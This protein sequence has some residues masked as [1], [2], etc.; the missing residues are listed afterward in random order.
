MQQ[1]REIEYGSMAY[2][3]SL[4][5]RNRVMRIPLGRNL[6]EEDL[7]FERDAV[8][9]GAYEA[10]TLIGTGVMVRKGDVFSLEFLC[11]DTACQRAG[12]GGQLLHWLE[13]YARK[14]Q[15]DKITMHARTSAQGFYE[16]H[17]YCATNEA[18]VHTGAPV[19]H[20]IMEKIIATH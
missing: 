19:P 7:T 13:E 17:G 18:F 5:L 1:L 6:Y 4:E 16:R 3:D 9:V 2:R 14:A 20:V 15:V 11:V 10:E 8:M 12:T